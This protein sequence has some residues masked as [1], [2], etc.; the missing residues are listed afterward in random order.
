MINKTCFALLVVGSFGAVA[1][2]SG[3][4]QEE[5]DLEIPEGELGQSQD[6]VRESISG[7]LVRSTTAE[8]W[9]I[10]NSWADT[11]TVNANKAGVAW[12]ANSGLSWPQKYTAWVSSFTKT[13]GA[14]YGQTIQFKTPYGKTMVGPVLECADVAV[15]LRMTFASW[16]HLPF[17]LTGSYKGKS[18]YFGHFGVVGSDGNPVTGFTRFKSSYSNYESSWTS[19]QAWPKDAN[20][21]TK[22]VGADDSVAA[23]KVDGVPFAS[24]E[25]AGAYFDEL[26]LNKRAGYLMVLLDTY[27]GSMNMA[28]GSNLFHIQPAATSAG[29]V[30]VE[31]WQRT[32]IG[33]VLPVVSSRMT[34]S[35]KMRASVA[36][37][38]M[39]RRQPYWESE[40]QSAMYFKS[41]Y[42]GGR[43]TTYD[44]SEYA[45]LGGGIRRWRTPVTKSG[46]WNNI[47]PV[48]DRTVYIEDGSI[49]AI[50]SRPEQFEILLA[51]ES[52]A[53]QRDA[54]LATIASARETLRSKPAS[55]SQRIRREDAFESLYEVMS[56]SF[57]KSAAQV[58]A[59][60]RT[61]EDYVFA[62]L[63]YTQSKTCCWNATTPAMASIILDYAK[64]EKAAADA[65]HVCKQP[66]A[67]RASGGGRYD[68]FKAHAASLGKAAE[69]AEWSEGESC[70]QRNV[71]ED[72]LTD[73]GK[74]PLCK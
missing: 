52:P 13:A 22:H 53:A 67:F 66:T 29:D 6:E 72:T 33:H 38:S 3:G 42:A 41:E 48:A 20:L 58:D 62:E 43:G 21:R 27:F 14:N 7:P 51:E 70:P 39:P 31:R 74:T 59:Q 69:W 23:L 57:G 25:G 64:K 36:S 61:L 60:Y 15:W 68:V 46:R 5:L 50:A 26:F 40:A 10:E 24:G 45:K 1:G 65:A 32:G 47:V 44:G 54:A 49:E 71:T 2:C 63:E 30:L 28:D 19:G 55:C 9:S 34:A 37:G 4:S 56:K 12:P 16:Y 17:Y 8:V 73:A 35:G 18:V 11:G